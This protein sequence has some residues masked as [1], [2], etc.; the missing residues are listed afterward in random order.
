MNHR[1]LSVIGVSH[2]ALDQ[3]CEITAKYGLH[4][5]MTGAGGGGCA[6]TLLHEG[7]THITTIY[8]VKPPDILLSKIT[9]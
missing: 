2:S 1:L 9:F 8:H 7:I 6:F 3:V 4:S 5:K